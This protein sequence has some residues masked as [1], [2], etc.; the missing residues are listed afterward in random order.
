MYISQP[1]TTV[2]IHTHNNVAPQNYWYTPWRSQPVAGVQVSTSQN[3]RVML[4][5]F[6]GILFFISFFVATGG[7]EAFGFPVLFL[8][9]F[10]VLVPFSI[11]M[12]VRSKSQQVQRSI[13]TPTHNTSLIS[14]APAQVPYVYNEVSTPSAPPIHYV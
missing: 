5:A 4:F 2:T 13:I 1:Q 10:F 9:L 7:I 14:G 11:A 12:I 6:F 3:T 8:M